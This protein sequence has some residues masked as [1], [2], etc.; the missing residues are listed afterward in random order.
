MSEYKHRLMHLREGHN[1]RVNEISKDVAQWLTPYVLGLLDVNP[2]RRLSV[3]SLSKDT[4]F[5][6]ANLKLSSSRS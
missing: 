4:R 5:I 1:E 6:E 3:L 2:H